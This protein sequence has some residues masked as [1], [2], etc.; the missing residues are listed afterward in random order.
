MT[1]INHVKYEKLMAEIAGLEDRIDRLEKTISSSQSSSNGHNQE[2]LEI[3][4][5]QLKTELQTKQNELARMSHGCDS[6]RAWS[7]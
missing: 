6:H 7:G 2:T 5:D 1:D 3:D 4:L